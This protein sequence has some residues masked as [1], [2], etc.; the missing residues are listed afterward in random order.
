MRI[1]RQQRFE[2]FHTLDF[3]PPVAAAPFF[4]LR[5]IHFALSLPPLPWFRRKYLLRRAFRG[6]LPEAVLERS[7][8]P[9]GYLLVSL[10][11]MPSSA[12]I[13]H[14]EGVPEL[15]TYVNRAAVPA[16]HGVS[17]PA[18]AFVN[19][20]PAVLNHWLKM[21]AALHQRTQ[22]GARIDCLRACLRARIKSITLMETNS[23][24]VQ[25]IA[26][27]VR[28][29]GERTE[30]VCLSGEPAG[31][32]EQI[33]VIHETPFSQAVRRGSRSGSSRDATGRCASTPTF[34]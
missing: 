18:A 6:I 25:Q 14:W 4:D 7:K 20:R 1:D 30:Q 23:D 24:K 13:D 31:P 19:V 33:V 3:C 26:V 12:W 9:L 21:W 22:L 34:C 29:A 10:L 11:G 16:I 27:V 17:D 5:V 8:Q 15:E 2:E 32:P 28:G